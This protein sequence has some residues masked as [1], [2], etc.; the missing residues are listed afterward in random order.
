MPT[1]NDVARDLSLIIDGPGPH[2]LAPA[3]S[4]IVPHAPG[5]C[6]KVKTVFPPLGH[7][8][9]PEPSRGRALDGKAPSL[10]KYLTVSRCV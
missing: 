7:G 8:G 4:S 5:G 6:I 10:A 3:F 9:S 2:I 1:L